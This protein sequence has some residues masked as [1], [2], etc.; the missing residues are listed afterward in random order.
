[1]IQE[2][3]ETLVEGNPLT[4]EQAAG[5]MRDMMRG[6]ANPAQMAGFLVA[7]RIKGETI[8]EITGLAETMREMATPVR[9]SRSPLVDTC[10]TGGDHSGTFNISTAAA[11]VVAGAGIAV[12]KHGNRSATSKCGSADVLEVL[13]VNIEASPETVGKCI[14]DI[15]I[16]FLFAR[17]LHGAMKHV[18]PVRGELGLRTVFNILGPLTN[19]AGVCG[20]VMGVFDASLVEP[21]VRVLANL[22]S[23]HA[24]VVAGS[25]G[26]DELTLAGP[27]RVAQYVD[28]K[29]Q[30]YNVTPEEMGLSRAS[31]EA[32]AGDDAETN[33]GLLRGVLEGEAGPRRDIVVLNAAAGILAGGN[34]TDWTEA[35]EAAA[36]SIDSGAARKKLEALVECSYDS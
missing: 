6:E 16:G 33:A 11:F 9:T 21:L 8:D 18:A 35:V 26:L 15:G 23:R 27:S 25:D 12:A 5:A 10:G 17:S 22:G 2:A 13:G 31:A 36:R 4:R 24:I 30:S 7:L 28:G 34:G 3:I 1:M 20:Q 32:L 19:P 29:T 14:D